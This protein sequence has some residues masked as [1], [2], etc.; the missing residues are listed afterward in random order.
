MTP[1]H[2]VRKDT[3]YS[4]DSGKIAALLH[5]NLGLRDVRGSSFL[6]YQK[7]GS[8]SYFCGYGATPALDGPA[9]PISS[10]I[11]PS[12]FPCRRKFSVWLLR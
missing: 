9:N 7:I 10:S 6:D 12:M 3:R 1:N 11:A 8:G 5:R 2:A 4:Y